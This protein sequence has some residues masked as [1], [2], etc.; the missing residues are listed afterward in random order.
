MKIITSFSNDHFGSIPRNLQYPITV[1]WCIIDDINLHVF[2]LFF[3]RIQSTQG[4]KN[5]DTGATCQRGVLQTNKKVTDKADGS[6]SGEVNIDHPIM[7]FG[8]EWNSWGTR[9]KPTVSR[10]NTIP[11]TLVTRGNKRNIWSV[12][13]LILEKDNTKLLLI[14][15]PRKNFNLKLNLCD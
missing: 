5:F 12:S 13:K 8:G 1:R 7:T 2:F 10:G 15:P 4:R 3:G 9:Q 14:F 11:S 6:W